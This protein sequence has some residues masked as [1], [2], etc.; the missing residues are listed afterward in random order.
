LKKLTQFPVSPLIPKSSSTGGPRR[1]WIGGRGRTIG[2]GR[3]GRECCMPVPL[4]VGVNIADR[5]LH[6]QPPVMG[7]FCNWE[8]VN[9]SLG[10]FLTKG[11]RK[12]E[13]AC[14]RSASLQCV[15]PCTHLDQEPGG[16][17]PLVTRSHHSQVFF[18]QLRV[19]KYYAEGGWGY[20][21]IEG[22]AILGGASHH[23]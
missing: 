16:L 20:A 7:L 11:L 9:G 18:K 1:P 14:S 4:P 21:H 6:P 19:H 22:A 10:K 23:F 5:E 13:L 3:G 15:K 12:S 8:G 2:G 17:G